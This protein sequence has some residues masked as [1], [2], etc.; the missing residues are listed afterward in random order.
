MPSPTSHS[1]FHQHDHNKHRITGRS[2]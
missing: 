1:A 2:A